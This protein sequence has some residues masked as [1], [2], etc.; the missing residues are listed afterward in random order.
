MKGR[1]LPG[2]WKLWHEE[3]NG[4]VILA[5]RPD[6]F[7]SNSYPPACL[8]TIAVGPGSTPDAPPE[9]RAASGDWH[10]ALYL[11][12]DVRARDLDAA[13]PTRDAAVQGAIEVAR[14]FTA[15]QVDYRSLYQ[16]PRDAY[17]AKLDTLIHEPE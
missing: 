8:P 4:R 16:V 14:Q 15:G 3:P 9:R 7:D 1:T 2:G 13:Y 5:Y 12:P 6:I 10:V 17:L 11:E